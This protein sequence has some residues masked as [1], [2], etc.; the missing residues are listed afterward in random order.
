MLLYWCLLERSAERH[1][2]V[3]DFGRSSMDSP[4][5]RFKKQWGATPSPAE[6]QF[7]LREGSVADMRPD[8]PKY[9]RLISIW[10]RLPLVV[11][12][13]IGPRIVRGIP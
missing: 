11:T 13:F 6:W 2:A 1:Q 3:F 9:Q 8:N 5:Y 7:Y 10:R 12:R 4:T